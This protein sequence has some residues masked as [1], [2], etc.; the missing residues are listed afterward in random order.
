MKEHSSLYFYR[1]GKNKYKIKNFN[2]KINLSNGKKP[3]LT[4][5][6]KQDFQLI[7]KIYLDLSKKYSYKFSYKSIINYL[8]SNKK[9]LKINSFIKQKKPII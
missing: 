7:K 2:T 5:D 4:L 8:N 1:E 3:R 6:Y 9:L